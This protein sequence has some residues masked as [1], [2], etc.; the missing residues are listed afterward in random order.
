M[1][2]SPPKDTSGQKIRRYLSD[3]VQSPQKIQ[4]YRKSGDTL[5]MWYSPPKDTSGQKIRRYL[6][7]VVQSPQKI[8]VDRKSGGT[9]AMWCSPPKGYEWTKNQ[10]V[11]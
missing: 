10:A 4:V 1:W 5:A 9:L 2:Y 7:D 11:P 8:Q 6:S 3:V